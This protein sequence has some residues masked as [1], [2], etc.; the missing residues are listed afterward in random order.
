M[1]PLA[2]IL[3]STTTYDSVNTEM[4]FLTHYSPDLGLSHSRYQMRSGIQIPEQPHSATLV[5]NSV[6][7]EFQY[8]C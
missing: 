2:K 4:R 8:T 3:K 6:Q 5:G 7:G 1:L